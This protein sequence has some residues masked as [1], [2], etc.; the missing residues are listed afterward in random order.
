MG[1][2][3][4]NRLA[5]MVQEEGEVMDEQAARVALG[6]LARWALRTAWSRRRI[7]DGAPAEAVSHQIFGG[8]T[9]RKGED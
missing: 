1:S 3:G 9:P 2:E 6:L 4:T 5:T 7:P 8:Y